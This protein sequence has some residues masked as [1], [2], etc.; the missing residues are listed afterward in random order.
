MRFAVAICSPPNDSGIN[1]VRPATTAEM[2]LSRAIPLG[3]VSR[4]TINRRADL[5][6]SWKAVH[7]VS[8]APRM[9]IMAFHPCGAFVIKLSASSA[10]DEHWL[11]RFESA[12]I[13]PPN[14]MNCS[15]GNVFGQLSAGS[16]AGGVQ[17]DTGKFDG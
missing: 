10:E 5:A 15:H 2:L 12:G 7:G 6:R 17:M 13:I 11:G 4:R 14:D 8:P 16:M 1:L 3:I 9:A